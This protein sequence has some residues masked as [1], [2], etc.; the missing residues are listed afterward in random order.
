M[1]GATDGSTLAPTLAGVPRIVGNADYITKVL[2]FGLTGEIEGKNYPGGVMVPMG[3]NKD[4]WVAAAASYVRNSFGNTGS[5]VTPADV[6][7]VR[8]TGE[9]KAPWTQ[10][11]LEASLP[12]PLVQQASWKVTASHNSQTASGGLNFQGWTTGSPQQSGMWFQIELPEAAT[13]VE[14]Q[15]TSTLQSGG[16]GAARGRRS[17]G[18]PL[19][20]IKPGGVS[21]G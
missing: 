21:N 13:L 7:R 18:S 2:L 16:R 3:T 1:G 4:E 15:F 5:I 14:I 6:A 12:V 20:A 8:A 9:R 19:E 10:V 11:E 17:R